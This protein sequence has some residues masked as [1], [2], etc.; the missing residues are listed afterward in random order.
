M[1]SATVWEAM[2]KEEKTMICVGVDAAAFKHDVCI[3]DTSSA[4]V[5]RRMRIRNEIEDYEAL[6][7]AIKEARAKENAEVRLG[8]ESTGSYSRAIVEWFARER[9]IAV[10]HA[11]PILTSTYQ[12]CS[13]VHYAKNDRIDA[14]G[15]AKFLAAGTELIPYAPLSYRQKKARE[16][17][18][19]IVHLSD[20]ITDTS[21]RLGSLIHEYFPEFLGVFTCLRSPLALWI[22]GTYDLASIAG[23]DP[24]RM[25]KRAQRELGQGKAQTSK[26]AAA[27]AAARR[28]V[29]LGLYYDFRS[30]SINARHLSESIRTKEE[31]IEIGGE[32]VGEAIPNIL[33]IPGIGAISALGIYGEIGDGSA[34]KDADRLCSFAGMDPVVRDSGQFVSSGY[35]ISKKGSAYLR[36]AL[37]N[38]CQTVRIFEPRM[39]E[40]YQRKVAAGKRHRVAL[41]HVAKKL[42]AMVLSMLKSGEFYKYPEAPKENAGN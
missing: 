22:L 16:T 19:E 17:Y 30:M 4:R 32:I 23:A 40:V 3:Y 35:S 26:C 41:G 11:N 33:S 6:L 38:A 37:Y 20:D 14:E 34:F 13:K 8:V 1:A 18:R 24:A 21:N 5:V 12:Q 9:W 10:Y 15:I 2:Q 7:Q 27:V 28:S 42:M 29:C 25:A 39:R 36:K 31:L